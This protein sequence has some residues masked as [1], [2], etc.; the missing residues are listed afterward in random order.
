MDAELLSTL[1]TVCIAGRA[2]EGFNGEENERL[3]RLK[4]MGLLIVAYA[5]RMMKGHITYRPTEKGRELCSRSP[6]RSAEAGL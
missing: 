4:D 5:P 6:E 1:K 2:T 3:R